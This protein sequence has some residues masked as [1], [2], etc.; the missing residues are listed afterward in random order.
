MKGLEEAWRSDYQ[1]DGGRVESLEA[2][3]ARSSQELLAAPVLLLACLRLHNAAQW[4]DE[5][6]QRAEWDMYMQSLGAALQN[7]LLAAQARGLA[8]YLKGAPLFCPS[9]VTAG[10]DLPQDWEP[11]FFV[12]LGYPDANFAPAPRPD[13]RL[14]EFLLRR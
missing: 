6:R 5:R 2:D 12:L 4:H 10:L 13:R 14:D 9:A 7:I 3:V 11:A 1:A 8:G